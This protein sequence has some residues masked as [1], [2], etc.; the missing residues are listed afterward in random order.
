[1]LR[2]TDKKRLE[3][4]VPKEFYH[5]IKIQ[6]AGY[7]ISITKYVTQALTQQILRDEELNK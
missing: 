3:V 1:M 5:R 6:A 7:N 2:D 4:W